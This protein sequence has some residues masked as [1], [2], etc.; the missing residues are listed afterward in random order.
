MRTSKEQRRLIRAE[1]ERSGVSARRVRQ[2][3]GTW[4][5]PAFSPRTLLALWRLNPCLE[6]I[7]RTVPWIRISISFGALAEHFEK[8]RA[9]GVDAF[10]RCSPGD[11]AVYT[12][13]DIG[14]ELADAWGVMVGGQLLLRTMVLRK[15]T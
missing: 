3:F 15:A 8:V 5:A 14:E 4:I 10:A 9:V 2:T 1:F 13:K 12:Q 11:G 6:N 7:H